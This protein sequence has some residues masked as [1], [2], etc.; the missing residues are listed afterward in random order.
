MAHKTKINGTNYD[1]SGGKTLIGGTAYK[2]TGGRTLIGGTAYAISFTTT[3]TVTTFEF[4]IEVDGGYGND[5]TY[6]AK[7]GMTWA[8]WCDSSYNGS[9]I[10]VSSGALTAGHGTSIWDSNGIEQSP[11]DVIVAGE[12]YTVWE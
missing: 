4:Y 8:E 10:Y 5:G 11:T 12:T 7:T 3:P 2:I 6:T 1:V 9:G